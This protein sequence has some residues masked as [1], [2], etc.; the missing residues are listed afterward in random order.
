M[1]LLVTGYNGFVA[2]SAL[3]QAPGDWEVHGIGRSPAAVI[4]SDRGGGVYHQADLLEKKSLDGLLRQIKP[5]VLLHAAAIA[6]I[7]FC[8]ANRV[9]A[10]GM[11]VGVTAQ[12]AAFAAETGAKLVFCSTDSVFDGQKSYYREEDPPHPLNFYAETKCKAEE[13]VLAASDI[14]IV[15]RLSLVMGWPVMGKGNS[16]LADLVE[17]LGKG[18]QAAFPENEIRT[19]IDVITLGAA[20]NE[21]TT[22]SYAGILHLSGNTRINRYQMAR[23]IAVRAGYAEDL[24]RTVDSNALPGRAPRPNDA[25]LDNTRARNLLQTP[26]LSLEEGLEKSFMEKE[27]REIKTHIQP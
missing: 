18:E 11:N 10:E 6:N 17:K 21:L 19:P 9:M 5:D 24:I 3:A 12:I 8:E 20:L 23:Q 1:K 26:F 13:I 22:S 15:A 2:G 4:A 7:D 16:F 14:N 25:S 27:K